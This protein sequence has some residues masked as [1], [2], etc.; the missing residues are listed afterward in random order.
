MAPLTQTPTSPS[1]DSIY[2]LI[3]SS[4]ETPST[5][6][7]GSTLYDNNIHQ[8]SS[9]DTIPTTIPI[10]IPLYLHNDIS[11]RILILFIDILRPILSPYLSS[12]DGDDVKSIGEIE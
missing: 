12:T 3:L 7:I 2:S 5:P 11:K 1:V 6:S 9:N 4:I 10:I 8:T